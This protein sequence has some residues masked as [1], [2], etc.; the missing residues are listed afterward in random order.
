[1]DL[2]DEIRIARQRAFYTQEAFANEL[3]VAV[4]TV[5]RWETG[6]CKPTLSALKSLKDFC[7]E[8]GVPFTDIEKAWL[9]NH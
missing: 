7:V 4:S 1:M 5:N 9:T 2:S 8:H 3:H 6:K